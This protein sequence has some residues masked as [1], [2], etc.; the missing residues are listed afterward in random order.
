MDGYTGFANQYLAWETL[1]EAL[2]AELDGVH[3]GNSAGLGYGTGSQDAEVQRNTATPVVYSPEQFNEALHLI[4]RTHP[5]TG[6][7]ALIGFINVQA[8]GKV[9]FPGVPKRLFTGTIDVRENV[10]GIFAQA[11]SRLPQRQ[12]TSA[13]YRG[14]AGSLTLDSRS[15][16]F[17]SSAKPASTSGLGIEG[18]RSGV[19]NGV[20]RKSVS[21]RLGIHPIGLSS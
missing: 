10:A 8:L 20:R 15:N 4:A 21:L 16:L 14:R 9:E 7:K 2:K 13:D 11:T 19:E 3:T 5:V 12:H 1:D 6:R 18:R 17:I